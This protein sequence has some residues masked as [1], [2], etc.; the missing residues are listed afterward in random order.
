MPG[1]I[2]LVG[3][4]RDFPALCRDRL[5]ERSR[6][7]SSPMARAH[8]S[9]PSIACGGGIAA[10]GQQRREQAVARGIA[11]ADILGRAR[12]VLDDATGLTGG[13][14]DRVRDAL[15]PKPSSLAQAAAAPNTP[16]V[17]VICQPR[18]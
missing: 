18:A 15:S 9:G 5:S 13:N 8:P 17:E 12:Q 16:Q 2:G 10:F 14:S 3:I 1:R 7:G 11:D 4:L 6:S